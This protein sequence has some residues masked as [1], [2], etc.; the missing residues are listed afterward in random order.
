[1]SSGLYNGVSGL[2]L[3]TGLYRN[4][5]G[6]WG[7]ASGLEAGFEYSP[8]SMFAAG[9]PGAWYDIGDLSTLFQDDA[10]T[11]PVT[12]AGQTVGLVLDKSGRGNNLTQS[13][14][15]NRPQY[16]VY[17][18]PAL[19][20]DFVDDNMTFNGSTMTACQS[21][22]FTENGWMIGGA[23]N[24]NYGTL[25]RIPLGRVTD[26]I[27]NPNIRGNADALTAY[28]GVEQYYFV[29]MTT[30]STVFHRI[31]SPAGPYPI[32]YIGANGVTYTQT[33]NQVTTDLVA[34]GLTA[35]FTMLVPKAV[36]SDSGMTLFAINNNQL[37]GSIPDLSANVA[38]TSVLC[39][40]NQL[41]GS[42]PDLSAN[43][44]LVSF[45]CTNNQ[46][47]GSIPSLSANT[48]LATAAFPT[49]QLTGSIPSLS[50][51]TALTS[52]TCQTNQ[53][54]GSIPSLSANTAL[55][56]FSCRDNQLTGSI[57][58]LSANTA[59]TLFSCYGNQL[60]GWS[61]GTVSATL[62]D[63]QAQNNLLTQAAVDAILA[64]FVAAGRASGTRVL[65]LGGTGN[66]APSAAG[67]ADKATLQSRGW[68]VTTN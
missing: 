17:S 27:V 53:L 44:A 23:S 1:M 48:A 10:G 11:T 30:D 21:A 36:L 25:S 9:E 35:P 68:T 67:L 64:A 13:V 43:V 38:L 12:A 59:L 66:A 52:F 58:S 16:Q 33:A 34:Q 8:M 41:T 14:L 18:E 4:V 40:N 56:T 24:G 65:N 51:N 26:Y 45:N 29:G 54:T 15:A 63:F 55:T 61:G 42:I 46:L 37:T 22:Y 50:T 39:Q 49:N 60:T 7:G 6:L 19:N 57:P 62:G 2:S 32:T 28:F 47:T 5:S 3:G 31:D 20:G